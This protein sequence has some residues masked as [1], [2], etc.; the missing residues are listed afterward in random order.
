MKKGGLEHWVSGIMVLFAFS[1][2]FA[3]GSHV[4]WNGLYPIF[5]TDSSTMTNNTRA[6]DGIDFVGFIWNKWIYVFI[7]GMVLYWFVVSQKREPRDRM[8]QEEYE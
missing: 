7:I 6:Q 3:V 4:I 8:V 5:R 2:A 1:L